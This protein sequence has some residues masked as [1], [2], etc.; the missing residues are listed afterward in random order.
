MTAVPYM[1]DAEFTALEP[2][3]EDGWA[4]LGE[5]YESLPLTFVLRR[6]FI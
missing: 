6:F 1:T 2:L 4:T 5:W 3:I